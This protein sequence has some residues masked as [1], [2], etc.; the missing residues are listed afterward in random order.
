MIMSTR[1]IGPDG[2][3]KLYEALNSAW[4]REPSSVV[5]QVCL[6]EVLS[7]AS[8]YPNLPLGVYM[9]PPAEASS[10]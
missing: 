1:Y 10:T 5:C 8:P 3:D 7:A 9:L 2:E 4:A 6:E